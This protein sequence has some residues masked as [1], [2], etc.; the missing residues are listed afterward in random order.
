MKQANYHVE[1]KNTIC[2]TSNAICIQIHAVYSYPSTNENNTW[3][4]VIAWAPELISIVVFV[5]NTM[6]SPTGTNM[7]IT[8]PMIPK[9]R[10][11][12][13]CTLKCVITDP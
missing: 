7:S 11:T 1:N 13:F 4:S 3:V 2:V 12:G 6:S 8:V 5:E 10:I 9:T